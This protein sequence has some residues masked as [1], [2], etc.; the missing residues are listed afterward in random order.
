MKIVIKNFVVF[1]LV[2]FLAATSFPQNASARGS[3][4][5]VHTPSHHHNTH[6][7]TLID[8]GL[9]WLERGSRM[10]LNSSRI[11]QTNKEQ[12]TLIRNEKLKKNEEKMSQ[13][14]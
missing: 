9:N 1:F 8:Q 11:N 6:H 4:G 10:Y 2:F 3:R 14:N 12:K 7:A 13:I 5:H